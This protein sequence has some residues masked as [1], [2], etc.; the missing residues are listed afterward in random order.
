MVVAISSLESKQVDFLWF[1]L[2]I[3]PQNAEGLTPPGPVQPF[4]FGSRMCQALGRVNAW[5]P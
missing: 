1:G 4:L 5:M 2:R 3:N